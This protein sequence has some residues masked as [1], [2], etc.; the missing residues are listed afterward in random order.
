M[1]E[2]NNENR[3]DYEPNFILK[4]PEPIAENPSF[5]TADTIQDDGLSDIFSEEELRGAGI[6]VEEVLGKDVQEEQSGAQAYGGED[7]FAKSEQPQTPTEEEGRYRDPRENFRPG[8]AAAGTDGVPAAG[9]PFTLTGLL[10]GLGAGLGYA[11][12]SIFS[13]MILNRGY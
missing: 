10:L 8:A 5:V 11:L 2:N 1:E 6:N 7:P 4:D 9:A 13:R 12:Y 3:T